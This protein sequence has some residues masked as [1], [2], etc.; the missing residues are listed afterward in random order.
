MTDRADLDELYGSVDS[1]PRHLLDAVGAM[2]TV[3]MH[4]L[5][6]RRSCRLLVVVDTDGFMLCVDGTDSEIPAATEPARTDVTS[7]LEYWTSSTLAV[8]S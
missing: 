1:S 5:R 7:S 3:A 2:P 8:S 4:A 6:R